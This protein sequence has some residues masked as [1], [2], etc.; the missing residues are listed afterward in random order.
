[1]ADLSQIFSEILD[2]NLL[3]KVFVK[4]LC[5]TI[6]IKKAV[7][8]L[9]NEEINKLEIQEIK[10]ISPKIKQLTIMPD[11]SLIKL[12]SESDTVQSRYTLQQNN[13]SL[14]GLEKFSLELFIPLRSQD[15]LRGILAL[16]PKLSQELYSLEEFNLLKT[17]GHSAAL[18]LNNAFL[19]TQLKKEKD[20]AEQAKAALEMKFQT[21]TG[22]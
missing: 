13:I 20:K 16:G 9:M 15:K 1:M 22:N 11:S 3:T 8:F 4:I 12:L 2:L 21:Q 18:A 7:L 5:A 19:F 17:I 10:N 6:Q 14:Q